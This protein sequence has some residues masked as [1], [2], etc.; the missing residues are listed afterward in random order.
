MAHHTQR[1]L[2]ISFQRLKGWPKAPASR[3]LS[4]LS[5]R[6]GYL[7]PTARE[8]VSALSGPQYLADDLMYPLNDAYLGIN[9]WGKAQPVYDND[10]TATSPFRAPTSGRR[11]N[12]SIQFCY[13]GPND[14]KKTQICT[15]QRYKDNRRGHTLLGERNTV[16]HT[17]EG[18]AVGAKK[19]DMNISNIEDSGV[20]SLS[21][22]RTFFYTANLAFVA[23]VLLYHCIC[24]ASSNKEDGSHTPGQ[25]GFCRRVLS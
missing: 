1:E 15:R 13:L 25:R 17:G 24:T 9:C 3:N 20:T 4:Y 10:N 23:I 5:V 18:F 11:S 7:G 2:P 12:L 21:V 22:V 8:M 6:C 19:Q 16:P 14:W